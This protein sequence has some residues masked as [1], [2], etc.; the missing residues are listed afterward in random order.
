MGMQPYGKEK[1]G[2][3][4][5]RKRTKCMYPAKARARRQATV[6]VDNQLFP[7][8]YGDDEWEFFFDISRQRLEEELFFGWMWMEWEA[9]KFEPPKLLEV[10]M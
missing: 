8:S 7:D 5:N 9:K 2:S 4:L 6:D 10:V 1:Y 3:D